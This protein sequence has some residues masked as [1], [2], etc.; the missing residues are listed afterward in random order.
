MKRRALLIGLLFAGT[1]QHALAQTVSSEADNYPARPITLVI[2]F[3]AGGGADALARH[4]SVKLG[5]AWKVPV[6]VENRTG[7][8]GMIAAAQV[9]RAQPDGY[10]VY[11]GGNTMLQLPHTQPDLSFDMATAFQ[12]IAQVARTAGI[13]VTNPALQANTL[14]DV[15]KLVKAEPGKHSYGSYGAGTSA[16]MYGELI[17]KQ[18]DMDLVHVA[19]R[20]SVEVLS[21]LIGNSVIIG[22]SDAG[23][24]MPFITSGRIQPLAVTGTSRMQQLPDVPT[25]R[26]AGLEGFDV[27]GWWGLFMPAG[28]PEPIVE[29]FSA[30]INRIIQSEDYRDKL[31]SL[32]LMPP[33]WTSPQSFAKGFHDDG[34]FWKDVIQTTGVGNKK[35]TG[36]QQ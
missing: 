28:T 20:G 32:G 5:E 31:D 15:V 21:A 35:E 24:A 4:F 29:K 6:V 14:D 12:P 18:R 3:P 7:A 30:E 34:V 33:A 8:S 9:A 27:Y 22:F 17:N 26:E 2:G 16:Q 10:T 1:A 23:S 25:A 13:V 36:S 19:Y 11:V